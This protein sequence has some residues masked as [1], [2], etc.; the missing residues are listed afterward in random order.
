MQ[1]HKFA[2]AATALT[3]LGAISL[4][5]AATAAGAER[6]QVNP[7]VLISEFPLPTAGAL[8]GGIVAGPD[9]ALWFYETGA[10]QIGRIST[11]GEISEFPIP[12]TN[13]SQ[14]RQGF[15]AVGP[16][17]AI[18]FTENLTFSLGRLTTDGQMTET[19]IDLLVRNHVPNAAPNPLLGVTAGPDGAVWFTGAISNSIWRLDMDGKTD[20]FVLPTRGATPGGIVVGSDGAVWFAELTANQIGRI[21]TEGTITEYAIPTPNS[22]TVR[23]TRG[24]DGAVWFA[25]IRG[26]KIGRITADGEV[27]E[28]AVPDMA[29]VGI[30]PGPDGAVWFTGYSSNEIGRVTSDGVVERFRVPTPK[31]VPYHIASGPDG[32]L[33]FTEMDG[34]K[35]GRLEMPIRS[36]PPVESA[37]TRLE[38][39]L[40][41][42]GDPE[43]FVGLPNAIAVDRRDNIYIGEGTGGG[44]VHAFDTRGLPL[45]TWGGGPGPG[46]G[47]FAYITS[48]IVD[49][50][51]NVFVADF[52]NQRVQ[53]FDGDGHFLAQWA[54]EPPAG[55]V[56][57]AL[58]SAGNVYVANH[59]HHDHYVQKFD[60]SGHLL[61]AWGS[62]GSGP[63]EFAASSRGGP[64]QIAIDAAGR[65]Y[66]TDPDN[67]RIQV[68]DT[69][70]RFLATFGAEGEDD[71]R[72]TPGG[73]PYGLAV[74]SAGSVYASDLGGT[75]RKFDGSSGR[76]L[77]KWEKTGATRL[78]ALD[79]D[80]N[81]LIRDDAHRSVV[82]YRQS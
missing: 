19:P 60:S 1:S 78:I 61:L 11:E 81:I 53:K 77:A 31:G 28:Y 65:V 20:E 16:D 8:P 56:G 15:L 70:G 64:D 69:E 2:Q 10:N 48:L 58:D 47:Q 5:H 51:S 42:S 43:P 26:N 13:A 22:L 80:D 4:A 39:L 68:F 41:I 49:N 29:P 23:V 73:G 44:K 55:P 67:A 79:N 33:W 74:D 32:A 21:T 25:E 7:E 57:L 30:T 24:S 27:R 36:T 9:G 18:W 54:T 45:A 35:I 37:A 38:A 62:N 17:G 76:L 46:E 52:D 12:T 50:Q 66:A 82:K 34:N 71:A 63:G 75:I 72:F 40:T 59:R 14:P 3:L 6:N